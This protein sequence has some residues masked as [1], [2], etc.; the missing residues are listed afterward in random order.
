[1]GAG[2]GLSLAYHAVAIAAYWFIPIERARA[3]FLE[4]R[5]GD[6]SM[7]RPSDVEIR[8]VL[9]ATDFGDALTPELA[10]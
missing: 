4:C 5:T 2:L 9:E 1:M 6:S 8:P 3:R 10:E 7:L